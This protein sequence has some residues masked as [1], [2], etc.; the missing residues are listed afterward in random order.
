MAWLLEETNPVV[1]IL[2]GDL[3]RGGICAYMWDAHLGY[4]VCHDGLDRWLTANTE[5]RASFRISSLSYQ[6]AAPIAAAAREAPAFEAEQTPV[7]GRPVAT[8]AET[9]A[10]AAGQPVDLWPW[11][12]EVPAGDA[13]A[14]RFVRDATEG[15][16][17]R[18][19]IRIDAARPCRAIWKATAIGPA[20]RQPPL[21]TGAYRLVA[22]IKTRLESGRA[23]IALRVHRTGDPG[24]FDPSGYDRYGSL[25]TVAGRSDWTRVEVVTPAISPAPDR[26][27]ILL[28]ME[29]SGNCWF[30]VV[31]LTSLP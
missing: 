15:R 29:G 31:E 11:E 9:L 6:E 3:V 20:F 8:F 23:G 25:S 27:H 22:W 30:D 10:T 16:D 19:S 17:D 26:I 4:T 5:F 18:A 1:T 28:E 24:L 14:V 13:A 12:T 7:I 2:S 21:P